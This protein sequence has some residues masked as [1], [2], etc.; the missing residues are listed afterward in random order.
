MSRVEQHA[1]VMLGFL[2]R[3]AEERCH[4]PHLLRRRSNADS[5]SRSN[6]S[7]N[8]GSFRNGGAPTAVPAAAANAADAAPATVELQLPFLPSAA[9]AAAAGRF[10]DPYAAAA[11]RDAA[12]ALRPST[13][14]AA[15]Q[16][17]RIRDAPAAAYAGDSTA[18]SAAPYE[19]TMRKSSSVSALSDLTG[20]A[21]TSG[22]GT[23]GPPAAEASGDHAAASSHD[24]MATSGPATPSHGIHSGAALA[25]HMNAGSLLPMP[26]RNV[27]PPAVGQPALTSVRFGSVSSLQAGIVRAGSSPHM[28]QGQ[29][30]ALGQQLPSSH[31]VHSMSALPEADRRSPRA[32]GALASLFDRAAVTHMRPNDA[33]R[34]VSEG[35]VSVI[36]LDRGDG[37]GGVRMSRGNG[38]S[39]PPGDGDLRPIIVSRVYMPGMA[40]PPRRLPDVVAAIPERSGSGSRDG[41]ALQCSSGGTLRPSDGTEV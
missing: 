30:P 35:E 26:L 38:S 11:A 7:V 6:P 21:S 32:A 1:W 10:G 37:R 3:A 8:S 12:A 22:A 27:A 31:T 41:G 33:R 9:A 18:A 25:T 24:P 40:N 29:P 16:Q 36:T 4:A 5:S 15:V 34:V 2:Q 13:S 28:L 23:S 17:H 39:S 20:G 19:R 14:A